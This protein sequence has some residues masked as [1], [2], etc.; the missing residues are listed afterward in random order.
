MYIDQDRLPFSPFANQATP[1]LRFV[2][3][4]CFFG[5]SA[6]TLVSLVLYAFRLGSLETLPWLYL[7]ITSSL[8]VVAVAEV[9]SS[10]VKDFKSLA[11]GGLYLV[12]LFF[13]VLMTAAFIDKA[14]NLAVV[15]ALAMIGIFV[16]VYK[17]DSFFESAVIDEDEEAQ[18]VHSR[19]RSPLSERRSAKRKRRKNRIRH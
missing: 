5:L 2:R 13:A 10:A 15:P 14:Y 4:L 18:F 7:A 8:L 6:V 12:F 19:P 9:I 1:L 16:W 17:T 3:A 11:P